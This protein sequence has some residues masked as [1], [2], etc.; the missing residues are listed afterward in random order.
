MKK[1]ISSTVSNV[2]W[3]RLLTAIM[4]PPAFFFGPIWRRIDTKEEN[5]QNYPQTRPV[6]TL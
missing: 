5:P 1:R 6:E 3:C 4:I 2:I